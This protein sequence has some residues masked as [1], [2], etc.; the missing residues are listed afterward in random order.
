MPLLSHN[1]SPTPNGLSK[2]GHL[3]VPLTTAQNVDF[4]Q[5]C[6]QKLIPSGLFVTNLLALQVPPVPTHDPVATREVTN[7]GNRK[8]L[9]ATNFIFTVIG[10]ICPKS[11]LITGT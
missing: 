2:E 8:S 11:W 10:V 5:G 1:K 9:F 4:R 3:S 7:L 6:N